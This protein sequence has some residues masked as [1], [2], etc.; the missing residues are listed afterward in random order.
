[1][2]QLLITT[3]HAIRTITAFFFVATVALLVA[4]VLL[5]SFGEIRLQLLLT[6]I[7]FGFGG[8]LLNLLLDCYSENRPVMILGSVALGVSLTFY[9]LLVWGSGWRTEP[10]IWRIWWVSSIA[11]LTIT[12][13]GVLKMIQA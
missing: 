3:R 13:L 5:R 1:M 9:L 4:A 6:F 12:H 8:T 11:T 10:T 2:K 7:G